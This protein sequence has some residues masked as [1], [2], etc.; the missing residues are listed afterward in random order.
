MLFE[1][2]VDNRASSLRTWILLSRAPTAVQKKI[3]GLLEEVP[4]SSLGS[5][6][7][8]VSSLASS[9]APEV[10]RF[11]EHRPPGISIDADARKIARLKVEVIGWT[12]A[13]YPPSLTCIHEPPLVLYVRGEL[14]EED[15]CGVALV[16]TRY[17]T[18]YGKSVAR[19]LARELAY[20][21]IT[22]ISGLARGVDLA[23]HEGALEAGGRTV[24]V[25]GSGV[26]VVYPKEN[27]SLVEAIQREGCGAV[28]SELPMGSKPL[29]GNF[30]RRN[31]IISGLS[32]G[33]VVVEAPERSGALITARLALEQGREVFAVPG[34]VTSPYSR[35][36]HM[37]LRDGAKL[38]EDVNDILEE[39]ELPDFSQNSSAEHTVELTL[40]EEA[41]LKVLSQDARH[42]DVIGQACGLSPAETAEALM[43]LQL[44]GK[45]RELPGKLFHREV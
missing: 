41:V 34:P 17:A 36:V 26:D 10:L 30:P 45:V 9:I 7:V 12:D 23:A 8:G 2:D 19:K 5:R 15:S 11:L 42:I 6:A 24:A 40:G 20:R 27:S 28:V 25:L 37:L 31:R 44:R 32:K 29:S 13:R 35:G 16:G 4:L 1:P 22:V 43:R 39:L 33:V 14:I 21:G 38:V 3:R 18:A